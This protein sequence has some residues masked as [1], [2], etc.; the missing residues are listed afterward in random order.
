MT[1]TT[2]QITQR[3]AC[4]SYRQ[5]IHSSKNNVSNHIH[6]TDGHSLYLSI[7]LIFRN[8]CDGGMPGGAKP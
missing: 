7:V 3:N 4:I 6:I 8:V 5:I 1:M 2:E